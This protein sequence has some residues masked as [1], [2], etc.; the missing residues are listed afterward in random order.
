MIAIDCAVSDA[1]IFQI[2]NE[3]RG[4]EALSD[5]A[6]AVDDEIN[7]CLLISTWLDQRLRGSATRGARARNRSDGFS[8]S[9]L[10]RGCFDAG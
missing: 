8:A 4:E 3:V 9:P 2:L 6:F 7:F 1:V 5:S 10:D